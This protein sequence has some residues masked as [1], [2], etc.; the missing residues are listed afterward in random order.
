M[1]DKNSIKISHENVDSNVKELNTDDINLNININKNQEKPWYKQ[2]KFIISSVIGISVLILVIVLICV[3]KKSDSHD[4]KD[5]SDLQISNVSIDNSYSTSYSKNSN[6]QSNSKN[7][8]SQSYSK[9]SNSQS[10]SKNSNSQSSSSSQSPIFSN[11][12]SSS[13]DEEIIKYKISS[14]YFE[15][16]N[17]INTTIILEQNFNLPNTRRLE[18]NTYEYKKTKIIKTK[19]LFN[20]IPKN[21]ELFIGY[22]QYFQEKK[23]QKILL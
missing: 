16:I 7:S 17:N 15:S 23:L 22:M 8:N 14:N 11:D 6:S 20:I 21:N 12:S 9:N 18:D 3:L 2:K 4:S 5:S 19:Y 13:E 10:N 1:E